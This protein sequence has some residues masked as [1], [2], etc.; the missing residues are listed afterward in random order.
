MFLSCFCCQ[1]AYCYMNRVYMMV[2]S[3]AIIVIAFFIASSNAD[4]S[5]YNNPAIYLSYVLGISPLTLWITPACIS[6]LWGISRGLTVKEKSAIDREVR[7][8]LLRRQLLSSSSTCGERIDNVKEF[9]L[10]PSSESHIHG[11]W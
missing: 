2:G 6:A 11:V 7:D 3:L 4:L 10:K 8:Q 1:A 9:L 5:F